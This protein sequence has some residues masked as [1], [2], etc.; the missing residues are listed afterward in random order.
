MVYGLAFLFGCI[1]LVLLAVYMINYKKVYVLDDKI[2][3]S[4]LELR[5][6]RN[7]ALKILYD[8]NNKTL[9]LIKYIKFKYA[10]RLVGHKSKMKLDF[11]GD[12]AKTLYGEVGTM[13]PLPRIPNA[14]EINDCVECISLI[15]QNYNPDLLEENDPIFTPGDKTFTLNFRRIAICIRQKNWKFYD[16]NTL[17]F[18]FLHEISHTGTHPRYLMVNGRR[19]NHPP[20]FWRV[21]KFVLTQAVEYGIIVPIDYNTKNYITY[22]GIDIQNNPLFDSSVDPLV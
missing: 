19:E 11:T 15:L 21:F 5:P 12:F 20:M 7:Q 4:V 3:Y 22:C 13:V 9:S 8:L 16:F 10:E 6:H 1:L 2:P 17:M 18:V 14:T